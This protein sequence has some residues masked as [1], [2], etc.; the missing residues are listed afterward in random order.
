MAIIVYAINNEESF[1]D[2]DSWVKELKTMSSPDIKIILIGNKIDL[3]GER[4]IQYKKGKELADYY[5]FDY[6]LE[7]SAKSGENVQLMFI[8]AARILYEDYL[9]YEDI[10]SAKFSTFSY[11]LDKNYSL[12]TNIKKNKKNKKNNTCC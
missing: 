9:R 12:K 10:N 6:F 8:K 11:D 5:C 1:E 4:K 3:I 2:I 7:T